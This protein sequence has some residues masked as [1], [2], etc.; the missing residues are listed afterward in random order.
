M[1]PERNKTLTHYDED[2]PVMYIFLTERAHALRAPFIRRVRDWIWVLSI[3]CIA[4]G[5][6]SISIFAF[7]YPVVDISKH[8]GRCR[9][10]LSTK[11]TIPLL[12]FDIIITIGLTAVFIHLLRPVLR[13][14]HDT[15][16][17]DH[18]PSKL[19]RYLMRLW[20]TKENSQPVV[21]GTGPM[22][23]ALIK[24]VEQLVWKSVIGAA[25]VL[26]PTIVNLGLLWH[27]QGREQG[28]LCFT[29]CILDGESSPL[30][31]R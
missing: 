15:S 9:I 19:T 4:L 3:S 14:S 28:W 20:K 12:I 6:G 16:N 24:A 10:G 29:I 7:I 22:N 26:L 1:A 23:G 21:Q 2:H 31:P 30:T 8:D 27:L 11:V 18:E 17:R 25:L 5:F 13:A